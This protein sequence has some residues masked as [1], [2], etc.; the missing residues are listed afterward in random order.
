M[1]TLARRG[2]SGWIVVAL[3]AGAAACAALLFLQWRRCAQL[4][5]KLAVAEQLARQLQERAVRTAAENEALRDRLAELGETTPPPPRIAPLP[6]PGSSLEQARLLV[7]LQEEL[8]SAQEAWKES[9]A[10]LR[11]LEEKLGRAQEESRRTDALLEEYKE[12]LAGQGRVLEAVQDELRTRNE[13][14]LQL[15]ATNLT[16][17]KQSRQAEEESARLRGLLRELEEINR[18][19]ENT[20]ATILRRYR[21]LA[22]QF[23]AVAE[24]AADPA[25]GRGAEASA[26]A[27][28][29]SVLSMTEEELRQLSNLNAQAGRLQRQLERR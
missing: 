21:E 6:S 9:Q 10:R 29:Q 11:E 22:D 8:A 14:L 24:Q 3:A 25:E 28:V 2:V 12:K 27:R 1:N 18:R 19:R 26:L 23:R 7:K 5:G 16:L 20:L 17:H 4:S 13:R 15:E